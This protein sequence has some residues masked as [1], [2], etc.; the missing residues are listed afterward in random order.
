[1]EQGI[2]TYEECVLPC[3]PVIH[4]NSYGFV[5]THFPATYRVPGIACQLSN[6]PMFHQNEITFGLTL[7][8]SQITFLVAYKHQELLTMRVTQTGFQATKTAHFE[9]TYNYIVIKMEH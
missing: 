2:P 3:I 5:F 4:V 7:L 8:C 6:P 1:M 9:N